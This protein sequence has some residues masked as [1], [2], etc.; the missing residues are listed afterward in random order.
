MT[1]LTYGPTNPGRLDLFRPAADARSGPPKYLAFQIDSG[2]WNNILMQFEIMVVL[3]WLTGRTIV[4]PPATRMYLLGEKHLSLLDFFDRDALDR[5]LDVLTSEEFITREDLG[6]ELATHEGFHRYM[7]ER[8]HS[9]EWNGMQNALAYPENALTARF[10]LIPRLFGRRPVG[11]V[12]EV[13]DCDILYFPTNKKHRMFG[14]AEVFFF[15][16]DPRDECRARTLLR[17]SI[18]YRRDIIELAEE[19]LQSHAL[20]GKNFGAM[21]IR[22]G[23]FQY[24]NTRIEAERIV[25]HTENLFRPGQTIYVATDEQDPEFLKPLRDRYDVVTLGDLDADFV[26]AIPYHW[27]GIV[28]TLICAAAPGR[29]VGTR[30]STFSARISILRGHMSLTPE[31]DLAGIDTALYYTQ[32]PFRH[33]SPEAQNSY[34]KPT[35]KH[36]DAL[37]ETDQPWWESQWHT[38]VWGRAYKAIWAETDVEAEP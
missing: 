21:H 25:A 31:G 17:D 1:R 38:P 18:R 3:A 27:L 11:L 2:G 10:E 6:D 26:A 12:G 30:L 35:A 32:P 7:S 22:R 14:V 23:D 20:A 36:I 9:P 13:E 37:G 24:H 4:S 5:H 29:F 34:N 33:T 19:A 8:G 15:F 28:E 16:G